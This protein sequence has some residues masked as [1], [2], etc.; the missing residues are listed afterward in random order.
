MNDKH[1][2]FYGDTY[3]VTHVVGHHQTGIR[4]D[5]FLKERYGRRSREALKRAIDSGAIEV[6]RSSDATHHPQGKSKASQKLLRGDRV[7]VTSKR[8]L[9]PEVNL[10]YS[11]LFEDESMIVLNKPP[12]LPVH[13]AGRFFFNT[14]L[15]HLKTNGFQLALDS[16]KPF[17]PVH[18]LDKETSGVIVF[19]KNKHAAAF[20]TD[21]FKFRTTEK[22][23]IAIV[24]GEPIHDTFE[25]NASI[26]KSSKSRIGLKMYPLPVEEG[27]QT[28]HTIFKVIDRRGGYAM[29]EC[30]PQTGRQH[31]IRAHADI[32]GHPLVGDKIY[33]LSDNDVL[34]LLGDEPDDEELTLDMDL[35]G[36]AFDLEPPPIKTMQ[37]IEEAL[38]LQRHALH[39]AALRI[40]HPK[41]EESMLFQAPL[42]QDL[43]E[44][45]DG[46]TGDASEKV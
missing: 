20:L 41:T 10:N 5:Q 2:A 26:G 12:K 24:H 19:A 28:A 17:F 13:P 3:V 23:Y 37:S 18:R 1:G 16:E 4:L 34:I 7:L 31:Q 40:L 14:L 22:Q 42:P 25:V 11:V 44:F 15:V 32:A 36:T 30:F 29:L 38:P 6:K 27:G 8:K 33:G 35:D 39:A 45:Y 43:K 21:Q 46:L 9:E